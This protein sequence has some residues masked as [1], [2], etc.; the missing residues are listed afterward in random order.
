MRFSRVDSVIGSL[1]CFESFSPATLVS[2]SP[3]KL[4][5]SN[6]HSIFQCTNSHSVEMPVL[7]QFMVFIY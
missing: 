2:L 4:S 1:V 7:I 6:S 3:H 5:L